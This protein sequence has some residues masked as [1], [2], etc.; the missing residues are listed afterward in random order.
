MSKGF[1]PGS[2]TK[3]VGFFAVALVCF[4]S[5]LNELMNPSVPPFTGRGST[6]K[7]LAHELLG[8]HGIALFLF[9]LSAVFLVVAYTS[10]R[11]SRSSR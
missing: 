8:Q 10:Y 11:A 1:V 2:G 5:G 3:W 7:A 6:M 9:G 4:F